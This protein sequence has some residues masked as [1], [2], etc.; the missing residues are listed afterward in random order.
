MHYAD[1]S[2]VQ[3]GDLAVNVP[4]YDNTS[5]ILGVVVAGTTTSESCNIQLMPFAIRTRSSLGTSGWQP[6]HAQSPWCVTAKESH[7][8]DVPVFVKPVP[9]AEP[10][11]IAEAAPVGEAPA[12]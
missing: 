6:L 8:F 10:A 12:E 9:K 4:P 7:K 5:E 1:G 2:P 3:L 11:P